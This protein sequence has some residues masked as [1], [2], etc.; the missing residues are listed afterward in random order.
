MAGALV[1]AAALAFD[2]H[3]HIDFALAK[4]IL[5]AKWLPDPVP[6]TRDAELKMA[7][8][9]RSLLGTVLLRK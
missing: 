6:Q 9:Q 8:G 7:Q 5:E 2:I 1:A 4:T 3:P